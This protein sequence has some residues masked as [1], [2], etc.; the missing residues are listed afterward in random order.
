MNSV[1]LAGSSHNVLESL[2][3]TS[4]VLAL[5]TLGTFD[6]EGQFILREGREIG[7]MFDLEGQFA[8]EVKCFL[9][10]HRVT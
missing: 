3:V 5:R 10:F 7:A 4:A 1:S 9:E 2:D 6:F 8:L